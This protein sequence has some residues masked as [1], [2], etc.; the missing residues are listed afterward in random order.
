M[1]AEAAAFA[2]GHITGF[3]E[4]RDEATDPAQIGSRGAG[5]S[6]NRGVTSHVHVHDAGYPSVT[7]HVNG[8]QAE[9]ATTR[10]AVELLVGNRDLEVA[11]RQ[12]M[13][14]PASQGFGM[15]AAGALS[16]TLAL[17]EALRLP[18]REAVWAAHV[19]EVVQ[20]TGLGDVVGA[21]RGGFEMRVQPGLEPYGQ[22]Q[23]WR[24]EAPVG[25]L[26]LAVVAEAV[27]TKRVLTDSQR[28]QEINRRGARCVEDFAVDPSL[29]HFVELSRAFALEARLASA[30]ILRLWDE[31]GPGVRGAQCQLG[32]SVFV[33]AAS[34]Q[35][36]R[37]LQQTG[38]VFPVE[39]DYAGARVVQPRRVLA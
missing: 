10:R 14:L 5:F 16:A 19:A 30:P 18:Q 3:F 1:R 35:T 38:S 29:T 31:L 15:S 32:G 7:V 20:R 34:P 9:A 4:I 21:A 6:V 33:F 27:S 25:P 17:A 8:T 39:V 26:T 12:T 13:D 22:V 2:P 28:R 23:S 36:R 11:I 37:R 24:P